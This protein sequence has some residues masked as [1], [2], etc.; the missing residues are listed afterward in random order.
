M[1][2]HALAVTFDPG[3]TTGSHAT[4][5][6]V[7]HISPCS[8]HYTPSAHNPSIYHLSRPHLSVPSFLSG[9]FLSN[10]YKFYERVRAGTDC[11]ELS[12]ILAP[13]PTPGRPRN[14]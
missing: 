1:L 4:T 6:C 13:D 2:V 8:T 7:A 3:H 10:K 5:V 11:S 12:A 14:V 9:H